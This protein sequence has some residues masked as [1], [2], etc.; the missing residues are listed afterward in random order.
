MRIG[1]RD[2]PALEQEVLIGDR[3]VVEGY[4][5]EVV[6]LKEEDIRIKFDNGKIEDWDKDCVTLIKNKEL[7]KK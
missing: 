6:E 1:V 4:K 2:Y 3:V 5:G 7:E